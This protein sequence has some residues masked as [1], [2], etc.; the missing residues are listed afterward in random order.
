MEV[1]M[2][3]PIEVN[4]P[5]V[6]V[7]QLHEIF[8]QIGTELR[9]RDQATYAQN[10]ILSN[11]NVQLIARHEAESAKLSQYVQREQDVSLVLENI[12]AE[13]P[14]CDIKPELEITQK[15]RK[16]AERAKALDEEKSKMEEEYKAKIA[17]LEENWPLSAEEAQEARVQA[18]RII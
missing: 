16:I 13:L 3:H 14:Q 8:Q 1:Q 6:P 10:V 9:H 4:L 2:V 18:I 15:I 12:A 17:S 5:E 7:D 11:E